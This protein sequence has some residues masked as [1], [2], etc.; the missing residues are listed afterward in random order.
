MREFC[1]LFDSN[2]LVKALAMYRSMERHLGREFRLTAVCFDDVAY[3]VL[4]R[5]EL[6]QLERVR[7]EELEAFDKELLTVKE[8]RTPVEYCWTSTPALPLYIFATRPDVDEVTYID[9][10]LLFFRDAEPLFEEMGGDSVSITPHR[11]APEYAYQAES[12]IYCVQWLTFRRDERGLETLQWW[13][14]RCIEWCYY[15]LE[16]G[17]LGDQKY[18]DDWPERFDGIC[19][20]HNKGGGLAPWNISQYRLRRE[21]D[22]IR[23]DDDDLVFFHYHRVKVASGGRHDWRPPGYVITPHQRKLVYD[24]YMRALD[25]ALAEIRAVEP[26]FSAGVETPPSRVATGYR[27]IRNVASRA[28]H[29]ALAKVGA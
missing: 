8:D 14:D 16:D 19:E 12:G 25:D 6:P 20:I 18:L 28:A 4:D 3:E 29:R 13:H 2:Y 10:D 23:V 22:R 5:L 7:L 17:K 15:R 26:G 24:P 11:F 21:G 27:R 9:A 1:T